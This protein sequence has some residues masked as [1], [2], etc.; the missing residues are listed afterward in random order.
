MVI[1]MRLE[2]TFRMVSY[3]ICDVK[4][5]SDMA[6][7]WDSQPEPSDRVVRIEHQVS[8]LRRS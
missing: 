3:I 7:G 1:Y 2:I 4:P 8:P 5:T 6:L